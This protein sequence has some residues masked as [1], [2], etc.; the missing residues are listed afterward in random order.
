MIARNENE[1]GQEQSQAVDPWLTCP[2]RSMVDVRGRAGRVV[3]SWDRTRV[4]RFDDG[5]T[6]E[7]PLRSCREVCVW[8]W[9]VH[10]A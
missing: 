7:V 3:G 4:I 5:L 2:I 9:N 6:E 8:E 1:N 10:S